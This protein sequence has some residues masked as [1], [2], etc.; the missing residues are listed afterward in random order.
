M[1]VK[2]GDRFI[3]L[4]YAPDDMATVTHATNKYFDCYWKS[5]DSDEEPHKHWQ[6]SIKE[7]NS[8]HSHGPVLFVD[9]ITGLIGLLNGD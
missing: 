3:L 6:S 9:K 5:W 4:G 1:K 8:T 7:W 2:V